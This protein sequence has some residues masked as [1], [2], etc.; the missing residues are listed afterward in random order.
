V[1]PIRLLVV[2][3]EPQICDF[4]ASVGRAAGYEVLTCCHGDD[5]KRLY[6]EVHPSMVVIDNV[7]PEVDVIEL[8]RYLAGAGAKCSIVTISGFP[9]YLGMIKS[10]AASLCLSDVSGVEKPLIGDA[11]KDI[12]HDRWVVVSGVA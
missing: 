8:V 10:L 12:F 9:A 4:I 3:D 5:F 2:D 1:S 6:D 11:L 7:M